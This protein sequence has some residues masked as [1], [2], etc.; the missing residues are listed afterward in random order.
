M[1]Y[2]HILTEKQ[3]CGMA[4]EKRDF[5]P[6]SGNDDEFLVEKCEITCSKTHSRPYVYFQMSLFEF[7]NVGRNISCFKLSDL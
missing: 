2:V 6:E 3:E 1:K 4:L 5:P 7:P